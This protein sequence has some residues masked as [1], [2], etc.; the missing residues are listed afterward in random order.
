LRRSFQQGIET[1]EAQREVGTALGARDG[2]HLV[3]DDR[4]DTGE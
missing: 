1:F 2:V 4:L 3:D